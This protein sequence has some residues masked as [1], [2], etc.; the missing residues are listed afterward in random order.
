[1]VYFNSIKQINKK[2][3]LI[4]ERKNRSVILAKNNVGKKFTRGD[5]LTIN[6]WSKSCNY[7]F[8]GICLG[9]KKKNILSPNS[10]II[11][12]NVLYGTGV[13]LCVSYFL[14]RLYRNLFMSDYKRKKFI[15]KS[16]KLYYLR[17]KNNQK[18]RVKS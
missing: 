2:R 4:K 18:S 16:S 13:E 17:S 9:L 1:M 5:I 10:T 3:E 12:R 6:F 15:Y 14:N 11:L 8:E 7:H